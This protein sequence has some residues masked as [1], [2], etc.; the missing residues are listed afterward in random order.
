MGLMYPTWTKTFFP[1]ISL[2]IFG[3]Q[4]KAIQI[5]NCQTGRIDSE[6]S[7][8]KQ[9]EISK[10]VSCRLIW[11]IFFTCITAHYSPFTYLPWIPLQ[12]AASAALISSSCPCHLVNILHGAL[13]LHSSFFPHMLLINPIY[14]L[15][16]LL[17]R[18]L[19]SRINTPLLANWYCV[20][21]L[22]FSVQPYFNKPLTVPQNA[23]LCVRICQQSTFLVAQRRSVF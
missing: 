17:G 13:W 5:K 7:L 3:F 11:P 4:S 22:C 1:Y 16:E 20:N 19:S 10:N 8:G 2:T 12:K 21:W 14:W 23:L 6:S 15:I 9:R 18:C